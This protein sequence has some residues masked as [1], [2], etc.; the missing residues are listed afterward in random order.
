MNDDTYEKALDEMAHL[1]VVLLTTNINKCP[2][3]GGKAEP[4]I[5]ITEDGLSVSRAVV[6]NDCD[7]GIFKIRKTPSE[8]IG[9]TSIEE[10][11][12]AWNRRCS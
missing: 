10:A 4:R 11:I 2:F 6:C 8:W 1:T 3:C 9:F 7:I 12:D 5:G